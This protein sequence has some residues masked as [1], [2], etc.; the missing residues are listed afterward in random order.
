MSSETI[1]GLSIATDTEED[2]WR[3]KEYTIPVLKA[4]YTS[5]LDDRTATY[6]YEVNEFLRTFVEFLSRSASNASTLYDEAAQ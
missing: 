1:R 5:S 2:I 6:T 4:T 3:C